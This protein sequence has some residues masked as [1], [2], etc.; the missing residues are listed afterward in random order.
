MKKVLQ[1]IKSLRINYRLS[2][3]DEQFVKK[4]PFDQFEIWMKDAL[5]KKV[6]EPNAMN[7]STVKNGRPSSRIVLLRGLD[8]K[9]FEFYTNYQSRKG[10]EIEENAFASLTFFWPELARQVRIEG[11]LEKVS[12]KKSN[13]YFKTRPRSSQL[14]A[15]ASHQSAEIEGRQELMGWYE[16]FEEKFKGKKVPRPDYWGGYFLIPDRI[17]FWQ[18]RENRLHD[19][20]LYCK[21][22]ASKWNIS[23]LSP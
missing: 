11:V 19:R 17:E 10:L 15:W 3:L 21:T 20:M 18:G 23:R 4:N 14:G 9:G 6:N 13:D 2:E 16:L 1:K 22:T 5:K 7:L 8:K 12:A